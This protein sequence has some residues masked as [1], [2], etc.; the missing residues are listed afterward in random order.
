MNI[1]RVLIFL[2]LSILTTCAATI[3]LP[4]DTN[5]YFYAIGYGETLRDAKTDA[6][7]TISAKISVNVASNFSNSVTANRQSGNEDV[8]STTKSEVVSKSKNIEYTDVKVQESLND[9]KQW[10]VLVEVDRAILTATY[11]RKLNVVDAKLKAE[12]EIYKEAGYFEKLKISAGI[13]KYL[14]E[15]DSFFPLLHALDSDYDDSKYS[16]RYMNYTKEM[17]KAKSELVF[18]IISDKN[19]EPLAS[20]IRSQLSLE[21][22]T[23]HNKNYNV[24]IK[25]TTTAKT[26]KYRSTNDKFAKLTF[27]L[28]DTTIK[29]TDKVG[30]VVSNVLYKTKS[31]SSEGFEDAIARTA[32]YEEM[33]AKEGIISFIT[34]N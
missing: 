29:A 26:R 18:K 20:L 32:K 3:S 15:T 9:G 6:L 21:N 24:L 13:N 33:I 12:W 16:S 25:I 19:S 5:K 11:V 17:R 28:R 27:A 2:T 23:F 22:A 31:G 8:L 10:I 7:A 1:K 14:K 30:N 4:S 34:G